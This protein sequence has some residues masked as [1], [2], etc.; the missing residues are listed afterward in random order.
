MDCLVRQDFDSSWDEFVHTHPEGTFFHLWGWRDVLTGSFGYEPY[1]LCAEEGGQ[2]H[3]ILPLFLV[4]SLLF[5]RSVVTIPLGVYGGPVATTDSAEAALLQM[6]NDI[7][8]K[9]RARY[10]EI[11]GNPYRSQRSLASM[12]ADSSRYKEKDLY[13]TFIAEIDPSS[14]VNMSRIPRKQ[15]RMIRQG[16][17]HG[18]QAV[19]D[20]SR[21]REWYDVYAESVRNL[22][23]PVYSYA[24]FQSLVD[25]FGQQCK[26]L[27]VEFKDKVVAAVLTFFYKD[28]ILPYYG[29]ALREYFHLATNDFMY[30]ELMSYGAANGYRIFDFGRSKKGTG[31]FDFKKHW[32]FEPRP[33]PYWYHSTNGHAVPDTSPMNRKLQWA[34]RVWRNLPIAL[35]KGL[36]PHISRHIP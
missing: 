15:R 14:E 12:A 19:I 5:G 16:Q 18:L 26:V 3:G 6:A 1:Y 25:S 33:L 31:S 17:K 27:L 9:H 35:T 22:G 36:G 11:R 7:T 13:V 20:N 29:G 21:L 32:G 4:R 24:Y 28:Q 23:T 10:L 2:I 34:I 8:Q 30:W